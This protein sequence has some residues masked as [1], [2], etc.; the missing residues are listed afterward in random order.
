M[1]EFSKDPGGGGGGGGLLL[2]LKSSRDFLL[3]FLCRFVFSPCFLPFTSLF[4]G[5]FLFLGIKLL[6][7]F[8]GL[9][10][11]WN[12]LE[13]WGFCFSPLVFAAD[14]G[15]WALWIFRGFSG[16]YSHLGFCFPVRLS[17]EKGTWYAF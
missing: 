1:V 16:A 9:F 7:L 14:T 6:A 2:S 17:K 13:I 12:C 11:F 10:G 3:L 8:L 4:L 15:L 5:G